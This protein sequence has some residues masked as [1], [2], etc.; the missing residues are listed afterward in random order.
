MRP[1]MAEAK[2]AGIWALGHPREIGG[3]GMPFADYVLINEVIGRSEHAIVALGTHTLQ[4]ALMLHHFAAKEW[5]DR[6]L[7]PLVAGEFFPSVSMTEPARC[8]IRSDA[9]AD[10]RACWSR[11]SGASTAASGSRPGPTAPPSPRYLRA[12]SPTAPPRTRRSR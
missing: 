8:V 7:G 6:Y 3:H 12:P 4:D 1:L 11:A 2:A 9:A 5:K 10:V